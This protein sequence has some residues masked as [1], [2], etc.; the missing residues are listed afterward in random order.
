MADRKAVKMVSGQPDFL[1][2]NNLAC[3]TAGGKVIFATDEW[4][5]PASNL[6]KVMTGA[7]SSWVYLA[8][9][10]AWMWTHPS[11]LETTRPLPLFRLHVWVWMTV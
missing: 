5:A 9:Y 6:L 4:F 10:M 11:L 7:S 2:F 8:S 1:Q 3:E